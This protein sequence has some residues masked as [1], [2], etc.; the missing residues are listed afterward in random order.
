MWIMCVLRG[1]AGSAALS[2]RA[3]I[4]RWGPP[5]CAAAAAGP[6]E[7]LPAHPASALN[8][9]PEQPGSKVP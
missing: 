5:G 8:P 9:S 3:R 2:W 7:R 6:C 1:R 4:R